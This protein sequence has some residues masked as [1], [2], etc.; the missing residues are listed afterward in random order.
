M[1]YVNILVSISSFKLRFC[2]SLAN[3]DS[4][5]NKLQAVHA[6]HLKLYQSQYE[7]HYVPYKRELSPTEAGRGGENMGRITNNKTSVLP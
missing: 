1:F 2:I 7:V 3:L 5:T 6:L 4:H